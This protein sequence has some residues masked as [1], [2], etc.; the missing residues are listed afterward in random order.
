MAEAATAAHGGE[1]DHTIEEVRTR[2]AVQRA[3]ME[4][5]A[6]VERKE[7]VQSKALEIEDTLPERCAHGVD[8]M[9]W[10]FRWLKLNKISV[11]RFM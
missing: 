1:N 11:D 3:V 9:A 6:R 5:S 8:A 7:V 2:E 10:Y 4:E